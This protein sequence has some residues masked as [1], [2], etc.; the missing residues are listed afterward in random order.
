MTLSGRA[1]DP[2]LMGR[3]AAPTIAGLD[4]SARATVH[5]GDGV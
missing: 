4:A 2:P 3:A 1:P 5:C